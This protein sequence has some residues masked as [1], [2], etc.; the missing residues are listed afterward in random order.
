[1]GKLLG[2]SLLRFPRYSPREMQVIRRLHIPLC[3][4]VRPGH[5]LWS[6]TVSPVSKNR[7]GFLNRAFS[8]L[9]GSS[10]LCVLFG[11]ACL[12]RL[13]VAGRFEP[14]PDLRPTYISS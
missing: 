9:H 7:P 4:E 12:D 8:L 14:M 10:F 5:F 13:V 11:P 1:M 3:S 6:V 2:R